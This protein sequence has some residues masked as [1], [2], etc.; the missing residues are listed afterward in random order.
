MISSQLLGLCHDII[1]DPYQP[2]VDPDKRDRENTYDGVV[3]EKWINDGI[4]GKGH[5]GE[6]WVPSRRIHD[7]SEMQEAYADHRNPA[8]EVSG[9]NN[10]DL[11]FQFPI[12]L[13]LLRVAG[14]THVLSRPF[15]FH[16]DQEIA[17]RDK[18][19]AKEVDEKY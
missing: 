12:C 14:V 6:Q 10:A 16:V 9:N 1:P 17:P 19:E 5:Y 2:S 11:H 13:M 15:I 18:D 8:K 7:T 4:D 3:I